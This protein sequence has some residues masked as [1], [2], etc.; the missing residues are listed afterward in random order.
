LGIE[1][2]PVT[3]PGVSA[4]VVEG[5]ILYVNT[6]NAPAMV[7]VAGTRKDVL[8]GAAYSVKIE[9]APYGVALVQ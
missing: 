4:R 8:T 7:A 5:R 9:L 6:N 1:R 3:P 2:G